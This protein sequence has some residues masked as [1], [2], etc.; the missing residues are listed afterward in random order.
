MTVNEVFSTIRDW[1]NG[2]FQPQGDYAIK[3]DITAASV[4]AVAKSGDTMDGDLIMKRVALTD[5]VHSRVVMRIVDD[6]DGET[7]VGSEML[8]GSYGNIFIG[9]GE[10]YAHLYDALTGGEVGKETYTRTGERFY[11]AA[12]SE[13]FLISNCNVIAD[14]KTITFDRNGI[15]RPIVSGT[16]RL[17]SDSYKWLAVNAEE[18]IGDTAK[19]TASFVS[20]DTVDP[21]EWTD[22]EIMASGETHSSIFSKVSIMFKNIRY[23]WK[24]L[25]STD[26]SAIGGGTVTGAIIALNDRLTV[27]EN[28]N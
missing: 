13:I 14:R 12:D 19:S 15:L 4:G 9:A 7:N 21:A 6:G 23:L 11:A 10:S 20:A 22:V 28:E 5:G 27:L 16:M 24:L 25:G 1:A 18:I 3:D 2:K 8:I 17:G 26:I